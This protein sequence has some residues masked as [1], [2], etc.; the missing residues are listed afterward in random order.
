MFARVNSSSPINLEGIKVEIECDLNNGLPGMTIVGLGTKAI[1]EAK[2]RV[3]SALSNS[4]LSLPRKRIT[5]NLSPADL[6]KDGSN[7]DLPIA[8]S[9][10]LSS[11]QLNNDLGHC[12]FVGELSLNGN[13]RPIPGVI[14]HVQC[15]KKHG[16]K[17]IFIP[18]ANKYQASLVDGIDI[19]PVN[20]LKQLYRHL[21]LDESLPNIVTTLDINQNSINPIYDFAEIKGQ[22]IAKRALEI[23]ASG[24]HNVL[25]TGPPGTGKT[26]L[27]KAVN[28]IL[29]PLEREEILAV[30]NLYSLSVKHFS[31]VITTRPFRS[32]HHTSSSVAFIGGGRDALPGEI[33]LA[34]GGVLFMDEIPEYP[35]SVLE[36]LRQPLEDKWV[37][38]S[39]ANHRVQYPSDFILIA[40]Q[41]PCPCGYFNDQKHTCNCSPYQIIQYQKRISGPLMDRID[42]VVEVDRIDS[43]ILL[44]N[45]LSGESSNTI[46][47]RVINAHKLQ[48]KRN[49]G[50]T[51]SQ[52]SQKELKNFSNLDNNAKQL[53]AN[54]I[55]KLGL[56]PRG[57]IRTIRVAQTISDLEESSIISASHIGEA[58]Q[59][60]LR[61]QILS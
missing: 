59:Y 2:E 60:R 44:D 6:P 56:S 57:S 34:H 19:V 43:N 25:M 5:I 16:I 55:D 17:R 38:I 18:E 30:T 41:N 8:I 24:R 45:S 36:S 15:A 31:E 1:D 9:I 37:S 26:M 39:R 58:L 35:R 50:K 20:N 46:K 52:L 12:S 21:T 51:N 23:A 7:Y 53:L 33:S 11:G 54:A 32:P 28:G 48:I 29:P 3:K 22:S 27:A 40:T 4:G 47:N 14:V 10:L 13:I 49:K 42:I 61:E